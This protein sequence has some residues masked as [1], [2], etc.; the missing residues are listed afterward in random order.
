MAFN[1]LAHRSDPRSKAG[2]RGHSPSRS[3]VSL[4]VTGNGG[5]QFGVEVDPRTLGQLSRSSG[6]TLLEAHTVPLEASYNGFG[7]LS[8]QAQARLLSQENLRLRE[9]LSASRTHRVSRTLAGA[10]FG[11]RP[12]TPELGTIGAS[13]MRPGSRGRNEIELAHDQML[14]LGR[15]WMAD[16]AGLPGVEELFKQKPL[17][18]K[19][20]GGSYGLLQP[21]RS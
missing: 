15:A 12:K 2:T 21:L 10:Q 1:R 13:S 18:A 7:N 9:A 4:S 8:D 3:P 20:P 11:T 16:S 14:N 17:H 6:I 5:V 19:R